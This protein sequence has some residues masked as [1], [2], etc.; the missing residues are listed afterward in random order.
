[1]EQWSPEVKRHVLF[2]IRINEINLLSFS[3]MPLD[4]SG[5]TR[6][7]SLYIHYIIIDSCLY[8]TVYSVSKG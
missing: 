4:V 6:L 2:D 7:L 3:Y 1:M 8:Y 5:N